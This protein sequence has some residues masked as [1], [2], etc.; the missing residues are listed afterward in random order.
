MSLSNPLLDTVIA[1]LSEGKSFLAIRP[2]DFTSPECSVLFEFVDGTEETRI[3]SCP[4]SQLLR[5]WKQMCAYLR[6]CHS[7]GNAA[8]AGSDGFFHGRWVETNQCGQKFML[9]FENNGVVECSC[10]GETGRGTYVVDL[11]ATPVALDMDFGPNHT[12]RTIVDFE[13][14]WLMLEN[15]EPGIVRPSAFSDDCVVMR[16]SHA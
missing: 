15:N 2:F 4:C 12:V 10:D 16:R 11:S 8:W 6:N 14:D 7:V 13:G 1:F 9:A 5:W 3:F